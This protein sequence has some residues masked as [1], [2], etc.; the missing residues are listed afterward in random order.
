MEVQPR[1]SGDKKG[2]THDDVVFELAGNLLAHLPPLIPKEKAKADLFNTDRKGRVNSLTTVL[3]QEVDRYNNLL[4]IIKISLTQ[5]QKAVKGFLVMSEKLEKIYNSFLLNLVPE[6]WEN[7]AYPS[8][9]PLGSWMKDLALRVQFITLWLKNGAPT[10]FWISGF[11]FPQGFL[12][13]VLQNYARKYDFPID[14]LSFDFTVLPNFR[15]QETYIRLMDT[16]K[17]EEIHPEDRTI[18]IPEDGVLIHGLFMDGFRWDINTMMIADSLS[19]VTMEPMPMIHMK[20]E[21][22]FKPDTDRYVAPL[23]KT[24]TRAGVLSTTGIS[25]NFITA[26]PLP[27]SEPQERWISY[28]AALL[29]EN[30]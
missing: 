5:L 7:A 19:G 2:R 15:D 29:C 10:S 21:M 9:K 13:G 30:V 3:V 26:I 27:S 4:N 11:F 20:P 6:A 12:T 8:L 18:A 22:D 1:T 17:Y 24:S 14:H 28:G 23:Y 25:T 16:L